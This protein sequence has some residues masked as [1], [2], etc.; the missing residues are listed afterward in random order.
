MRA[1]TCSRRRPPG[2][3]DPIDRAARA[4]HLGDAESSRANSI[5]RSSGLSAPR[6]S[7][8]LGLRALDQRRIAC[9]ASANTLFET[10]KASTL[11]SI[12]WHCAAL[13]RNQRHPHGRLRSRATA[14]PSS[15]A[16]A[17]PNSPTPGATRSR[18]SASAGF[19]AIAPDQRGYGLTDRPQ[20]IDAYDIH[21]L[22]G[23]LVGMLDALKIEKAVFVGH[24]WGGFVTWADAA[25]APAR[26]CS[27]SSASTRRSCRA[28]RWTRSR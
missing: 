22:T 27:A 23:D 8:N 28:R 14:C 18:R 3:R 19:R 21:H 20:A 13:R 5:R 9:S 25:A 24:D 10:L 26:A 7:R 2:S 16:T 12:N 1:S 11:M 15:C 6:C 17:S 4:R